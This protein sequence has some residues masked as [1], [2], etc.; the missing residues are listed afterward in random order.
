MSGEVDMDFFYGDQKNLKNLEKMDLFFDG[1]DSSDLIHPVTAHIL[2]GSFVILI[3]IVLTNLLIGL[4]VADIKVIKTSQYN[5][6]N[7]V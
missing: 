2:Y 6:Y 7:V 3:T 1:I 5:L 4:A